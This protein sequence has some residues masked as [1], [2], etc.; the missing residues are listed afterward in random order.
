MTAGQKKFLAVMGAVLVLLL[1]IGAIYLYNIGA[2]SS[3][4]SYNGTWANCES[5]DRCVAIRSPC[6]S[7]VAVN[8]KYLDDAS[9][10]YD[11]MITLVE[12]SPRI[13]CAYSPQN[14]IQ[15][16]A[17]CLSGLCVTAQ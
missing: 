11:H 15:P 12:D 13:S 6:D 4:P 17:Y 5:G 16:T 14:D 8:N 2:F 9:A 7:W 3:R 1:A 10:Y